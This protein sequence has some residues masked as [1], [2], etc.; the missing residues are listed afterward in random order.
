MTYDWK[1]NY[2]PLLTKKPVHPFNKALAIDLPNLS[3]A[4]FGSYGVAQKT[5]AA[6]G[7]GFELRSG[8][9]IDVYRGMISKETCM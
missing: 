6:L 4:T 1:K 9:R 3:A 5:A 7:E 2:Y 8:G